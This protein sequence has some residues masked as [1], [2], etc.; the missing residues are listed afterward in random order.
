MRMRAQVYVQ[1]RLVL[2]YFFSQMQVLSITT[3]LQALDWHR[4]ISENFPIYLPVRLKTN[5]NIQV[6]QGSQ[7]RKNIMRMLLDW[8]HSRS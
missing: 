5:G 2:A 3:L 7:K 8:I 1:F 6:Q 4:S